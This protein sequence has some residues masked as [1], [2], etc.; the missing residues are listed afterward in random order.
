MLGLAFSLRLGEQ[1]SAGKVTISV[2]GLPKLFGSWRDNLV[3]LSR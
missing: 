2:L 1:A 3:Y